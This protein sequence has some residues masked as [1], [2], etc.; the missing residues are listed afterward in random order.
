MRRVVI[1]VALAAAS[2]G[3]CRHETVTPM[4]GV[5]PAAGLLLRCERIRLNSHLELRRLELLR[6]DVSNDFYPLN[7]SRAA[8]ADWL[9]SKLYV[10]KGWKWEF[11]DY[12]EIP[13]AGRRHAANISE[14]GHRIIYER[15]NV[16]EGEGD[17]PRA[18]PRDC[19]TYSVVIYDRAAGRKFVLEDFLELYGLGTAS[20]WRPDGEAVAFSTT[21][22]LD[23]QPC[24]QLAILD[25]CG[26]VILDGSR[27]PA[28]RGMEFICYSPD[29]R[30]IA[31][32]RPARPRSDG[33]GGGMLV[34]IDV[35]ARSVRE[36][37]E[38]P[39]LLACRHI[40]RFERLVKWDAAGGCDLKQ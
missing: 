27:M 17:L 38:I 20:H 37:G 32:L 11:L 21:C 9:V 40:G 25:A 19:R 12:A 39:A 16:A 10:R 7:V 26:N 34:E 22:Y 28:L 36:V 31:A 14:D 35:A 2:A 6:S 23:G 29:G 8:H 15:P 30:R 18:Y 1:A 3:G 33:R 4:P 24:P 5:L 13:L